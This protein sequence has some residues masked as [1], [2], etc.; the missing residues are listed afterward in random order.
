MLLPTWPKWCVCLRINMRGALEDKNLST[1]QSQIDYAKDPSHWPPCNHTFC[2]MTFQLLPFRGRISFPSFKSGLP[3]RS[4]WSVVNG[5]MMES[6]F[7][8]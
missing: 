4:V 7:W 2:N 5:G 6:Q 3:L 8:V 1:Y